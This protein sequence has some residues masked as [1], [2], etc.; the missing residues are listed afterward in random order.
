MNVLS[1]GG[2][3]PSTGAGIQSDVKTIT[4]MGGYP[5]TVVTALT[6][7]NTT[8][9]SKTKP[10]SKRMVES[11]LKSIFSDFQIDAIKIGM[12]YN[13]K[14]ILTVYRKLKNC[15]IPI[16]LDP[17]IESTT[18]GN[19]LEKEA[20]P[21]FIKY[22]I[23][24]STVIT[25]NKKEAELLT[26]IKINSEKSLHSAAK[27]LQTL[28]AKNVIITGITSKNKVNDFVLEGNNNY[29]ISGKKIPIVNHGSGCTYSAILA[30]L[31]TKN[32]SLK[33]SVILAKQFTFESIKN[34][35]NIGKGVSIIKM[36]KMDSIQLE[37]TDSIENF[38]KIPLIYK[39]I[40]ECQ[41]NFVFSK[42]KPKS[43]N[44]VIGVLGRIVKT[45]N[46]VTQSGKIQYGASKH[47]ATAVVTISKKFPEI[48]S[49]VNL[50]YN[51]KDIYKFKKLGLIVLEYDRTKESKLNKKKGSSISWG[52]KKAIETVK[53]PPDVIYHKG[54]FGKEPMTLVFGES[55]ES[56][57]NKISAI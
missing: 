17:V 53:R 15:K 7:Q 37:L 2:S 34:S 8:N 18:G 47:V 56:V 24:I 51:Q 52:V 32:I 55:P 50:K 28:G 45:G 31:L 21:D 20:M 22:L 46:I 57:I 35:A 3:D 49:A 33:E 48:R 9:Y 6:S 14:I 16:I 10:V 23:S 40:P 42:N 44:D 29:K 39:K 54:D 12:V 38:K 30:C 5:L 1:I 25:P 4:L 27:K 43:I 26:K 36:K 41:T 19:L 11:Q 13:S